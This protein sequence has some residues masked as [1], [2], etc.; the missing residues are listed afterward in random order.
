MSKGYYPDV[1]DEVTDL[2]SSH[3]SIDTT[4]PRTIP[5][6]IQLQNIELNELKQL[7]NAKQGAQRDQ[8]KQFLLAYF[9]IYLHQEKLDFCCFCFDVFSPEEKQFL[10]D[11]WIS[12]EL[13]YPEQPLSVDRLTLVFAHTTQ[14]QRERLINNYKRS[15]DIGEHPVFGIQNNV[16][17]YER[18][19]ERYGQQF[20]GLIEQYGLQHIVVPPVQYYQPP[21]PPTMPQADPA[22]TG[23]AV[24]PSKPKQMAFSLQ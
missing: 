12:N 21:V 2:Q 14:A 13:A 5:M 6:D 4:P 19:Q 10:L 3:K 22:N 11:Q 16:S 23:H 7:Y 1:A 17:K 9:P 20:T 18:Y 24:R 8:M 15:T